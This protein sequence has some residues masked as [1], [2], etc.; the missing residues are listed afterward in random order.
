MLRELSRFMRCLFVTSLLI[1]TARAIHLQSINLPY[2]VTPTSHQIYHLHMI[3]LY[4]CCAIGVLVFGMLFYCL[5]RFRRSKGAVAAHF[6]EHLGIEIL[7]TLIPCLILIALAIPATLVLKNIHNT[8]K[9][10]I[11]IKVIGQ[12]WKWEYEY[13]D[14]GLRFVSNLSTPQSQIQGEEPKAPWYLLEVDHPLVLP[15][16]RKIRLL[17]TSDDVIHAWWVPDLGVKQDAVPGYVN[18]N[19]VYINRPGIYRGQCGELC[20]AL[21]GFM[22]IVV[23]ALPPKTYAKW[24][25]K[26][27]I[28]LGIVSPSVDPSKPLTT[29]TLI[30]WGAPIYQRLCVACHQAN[31][32]GLGKVFPA[33]KRSEY[34]VG[35]KEK[36]I[37]RLLN[38]V[39]G[40]AMV[41]FRDQLNDREIA[42]VVSYI[43]H[44]WGNAALNKKAKQPIAVTP[45]Q[46]KK[47]RSSS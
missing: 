3:A 23:K 9:P 33:L 25:R 4:V 44:E 2:G 27:K 37:L 6:H 14:D 22:P 7:W 46:V 12:Q 21:H 15:T 8:D 32:Q 13:L 35:A 28:K 40:S 19:W 29:E 39:Q 26:E 45:D 5:I 38:G 34:V 41:A 30:D 18:E 24:L 10:D 47:M 31:G 16:H 11:N 20:G 43:R 1:P 17:V 36:T 42:A